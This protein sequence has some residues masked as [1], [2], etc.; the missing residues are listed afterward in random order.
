MPKPVKPPTFRG[1]DLAMR[2]AQGQWSEER[3]V[4]SINVSESYR[5]L[6]Y[7]LS[8][9]G[10]EN[11][12][13]IPAYW[14]KFRQAESVG[15][16]PDILVLRRGDFERLNDRLPEDPTVAMD[17]EPT[18][19]IE[20]AICGIEAENSLWV[21]EKMPDYGVEKITRK[22][23]IAPTII[24]KEQDAPEL[25]AWQQHHGVPVC[26]VQVFFDRSYIM[27]LDDILAAVDEIEAASRGEGVGSLG[28]APLDE[29]ENKKRANE[30]QKRLGVFIKEQNYPDSR[31]GTSTKKVTYRTH[32]TRAKEFGVLDPENPPTYIPKVMVEKNGKIM[33]Y[34]HFEGGILKLSE[35]ALRLFEELDVR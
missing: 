29:K 33:S 22:D 17:D 1:S 3:V 12:E 30:L 15:K 9:V 2:Y 25:V 19:F 14:E 6:P 11:K 23:F 35:P 5:A 21:A 16:R 8:Q 7:G 18:P 32:H 26:V 20:A 13:D 24:V 27:R 31:T 34:V 28:I 10:P 4:E